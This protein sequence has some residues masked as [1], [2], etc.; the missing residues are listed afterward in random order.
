MSAAGG[1]SSRCVVAWGVAD[2]EAVLFNLIDFR[3][4]PEGIEAVFPTM[5]NLKYCF[6]CV[7]GVALVA[8]AVHLK[9][10]L[11]EGLFGVASSTGDCH[12]NF[13][14]LFCC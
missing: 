7:S 1:P 3:V 12:L 4:F 10:A 14:D 11:F 2:A 5:L 13:K 9:D 6:G 8:A